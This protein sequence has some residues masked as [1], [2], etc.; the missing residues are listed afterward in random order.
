MCILLTS[1]AGL[2]G[3]LTL[4]APQTGVVS[5]SWQLDFKF[6]DPQRII[7]R[8]PGDNHLT[9]F[10]YM[11]FE[12]TNLTGEDRT[13][14]PSF[15]LV[16]DTLQVVEGG[17]D[18]SPSVYDAIAARHKGEFPF[19]A[20][21][22]KVTGLLLQGEENSRAS[23]AVFRTFDPEASSFTVFVSGL[24]GDIEQVPNPSF[25]DKQDES[26]GNQRFFFVRR[27]L[28]IV[29]DLPGDPTTRDRAAPIRRTRQ[30]VMR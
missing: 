9:T 2:G 18:V 15:R 6:H 30:W 13:F 19:F 24:S 29:Y 14:Y 1:V 8:L 25:N 22:S 11:L 20:P 26:D 23:A 28:A 17:A 7:L 16:T 10:W 27:T 4:A 12:V 21:P 5:S 3:A